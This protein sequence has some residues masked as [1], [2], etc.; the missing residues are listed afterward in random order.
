MVVSV[1]DRTGQNGASGGNEVLGAEFVPQVGRDGAG[2]E[3]RVVVE[4]RDG[5]DPG[6]ERCPTAGWAIGNCIAAA[7]SGT[8]WRAQ[9]APIRCARS[10]TSGAAGP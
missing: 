10:I 4:V 8:S 7:R 9:A 6:H 3:G 2:E 1:D 5:A